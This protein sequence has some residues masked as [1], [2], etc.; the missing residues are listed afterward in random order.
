MKFVK[1]LTLDT[2]RPS[3]NR[4][5]INVDDGIVTDT[6]NSLQLPSGTSEDR[7]IPPNDGQIR[8]STTLNEFEVY[9]SSG[10]GTGWEL[11]RTIRPAN[12]TLQNLGDG[13]Y[14]STLFGP[15]LYDVDS[16]RPQNIMVYVENVYQ[17]PSINYNLLSTGSFSIFTTLSETSPTNTTTLTLSTSTNVLKGQTISALGIPA[18]TTITNVDSVTKVVTISNPTDDIINLGSSITLTYAEGTYVEFSGPVPTKPVYAL[19]GFDGYYPP[20][21]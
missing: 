7:P 21:P 17:L 19:L 6:A 20:F 12:I 11:V 8:Y 13:N 10:Q 5:V 9:N 1:K 4:F 3:S 16:T 18:A 2:Q 15:L 14:E